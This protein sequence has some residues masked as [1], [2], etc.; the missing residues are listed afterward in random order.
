MTCKQLLPPL[1]TA[2]SDASPTTQQQ[3]PSDMPHQTQQLALSVILAIVTAALKAAAASAAASSAAAASNPEA[4]P[5]QKFCSSKQVPGGED[6]DPGE[7]YEGDSMAGTGAAI[8]QAVIGSQR[9]QG[10]RGRTKPATGEGATSLGRHIDADM[11]DSAPLDNHPTLQQLAGEMPRPNGAAYIDER[12]DSE[13]DAA[14]LLQLQVLTELVSFPAA[15][16]PLA[17]QVCCTWGS[18]HP[19]AELS[20]YAASKCCRHQT[21]QRRCRSWKRP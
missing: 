19:A 10:V 1:A 11:H 18:T 3:G 20:A 17:P 12:D 6:T 2:A 16:S 9:Q 15:C 13:Q 14:Q 7:G 4:M 8:F 21:S 5:T